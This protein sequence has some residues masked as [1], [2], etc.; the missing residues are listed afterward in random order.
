MRKIKSPARSFP[1]L[2]RTQ[3][4]FSPHNQSTQLNTFFSPPEDRVALMQNSKPDG[5]LHYK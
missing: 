4:F 5:P 3:Q 2:F 1:L